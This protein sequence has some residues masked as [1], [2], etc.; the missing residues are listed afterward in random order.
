MALGIFLTSDLHLGMKFAGYH[1]DVQAALVEARFSSV[2]RIVAA[3]NDARAEL[4]V[5]AGDLFDSVNVARR[6][7]Q[8]AAGA[9]SGF[10]GR[11]VAVMPGNHDFIAPDDKLWQWFRDAAGDGTLLLDA[12]RPF[13]LTSY[14]L[15]ACLYPGP[16]TTKH[17]VENAI[18]WVRGAPKDPGIRWHIGVAHGALEGI[19][20]D[21]EGDYYHMTRAELAGAG[22]G[23][24]L[25]GHTHLRFPETPGPADRVFCAGTPEPD[26]L[27][28]R[29][30]GAAW[31]L[32]VDD[33]GRVTARAVPTGRYRFADETVDVTSTADLDQIARRWS[34]PAAAATVLRLRLTGRASQEVITAARDLRDRLA[35]SLLSLELRTDDL[36]AIITEADIER[37]YPAGSFPHQLLTALAAQR[38][39]DGLEMAWDLLQE[40]R[41]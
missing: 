35:R 19:S 23:L 40:M 8:R 18:G 5:V 1:G 30:E 9:L 27:D 34:G 15:D 22:V 6:D 29:H 31:S 26:G 38:D 32:A 24:W 7:V 10:R 36:R 33:G 13:V 21:L 25:L 4:L 39:Q 14:G 17:A 20:P 2:E 37:E 28:C 12:P 16:C 41:T 11:L 3:A